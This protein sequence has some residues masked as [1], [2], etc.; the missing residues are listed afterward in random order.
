VG[1]DREALRDEKPTLRTARLRGTDVRDSLALSRRIRRFDDGESIHIGGERERETRYSAP[2]SAVVAMPAV[3]NR[4]RDDPRWNV[5]FDLE[6][7]GETG[8]NI[9]DIFESETAESVNAAP[10]LLARRARASCNWKSLHFRALSY[11]SFRSR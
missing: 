10:D 1:M 7:T 2:Y 6:E 3:K 9:F 11:R 5:A 4:N 8:R